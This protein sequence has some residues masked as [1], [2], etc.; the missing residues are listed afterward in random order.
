MT[1][2]QLWFAATTLL[3]ILGASPLMAA[4]YTV[5]TVRPITHTPDPAQGIGLSVATVIYDG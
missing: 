5:A 2:T 1:F 3:F 4:D